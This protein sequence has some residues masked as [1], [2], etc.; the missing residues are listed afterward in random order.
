MIHEQ[1]WYVL[2]NPRSSRCSPLRAL[3]RPPF[4]TTDKDGDGDNG[5]GV[6]STV[7][8]IKHAMPYHSHLTLTC[9]EICTAVQGKT[10]QRRNLVG[11]VRGCA[12]RENFAVTSIERLSSA[13]HFAST[14]SH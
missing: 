11:G 9:P 7:R 2:D 10:F 6:N 8:R 13:P 3:S 5:M 1:V 4:P 14:N 12:E